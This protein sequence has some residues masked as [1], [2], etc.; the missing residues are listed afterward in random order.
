MTCHVIPSIAWVTSVGFN[1]W[2]R[3]ELGTSSTH[4]DGTVVGRDSAAAG[5]VRNFSQPIQFSFS[6]R[7]RMRDR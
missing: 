1:D 6:K 3:L 4:L 5:A 2:E 7:D